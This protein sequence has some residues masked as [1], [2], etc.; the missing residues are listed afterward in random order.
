M[1]F[2]ERVRA[3]LGRETADAQ[4][5]M[6]ETRERLEDDLDRRERELAASPDERLTILQE[7]IAENDAAFRALQERLQSPASPPPTDS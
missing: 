5:L 4:E 7:Q 1:R 2:T 6:A 3:W